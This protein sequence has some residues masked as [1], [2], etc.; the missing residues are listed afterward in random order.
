MWHSDFLDRESQSCLPT[1][2][3]YGKRRLQLLSEQ[4]F[5][6]KWLSDSWLKNLNAMFNAGGKSKP[7]FGCVSKSGIFCWI[8]APMWHFSNFLYWKIVAFWMAGLGLALCLLGLKG[9]FC[10]FNI[11][12]QFNLKSCTFLAS[13][14]YS[15]GFS[16]FLHRK[17]PNLNGVLMASWAAGLGLALRLLALKRILLCPGHFVTMSQHIPLAKNGRKN[18]DWAPFLIILI[19][20]LGKFTKLLLWIEC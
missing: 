4:F 11:L 1:I 6:G 7:R 13:L 12:W 2:N 16:N 17:L 8:Y 10:V 18:E 14:S 9:F 19:A 5:I 15:M 20:W 3:C